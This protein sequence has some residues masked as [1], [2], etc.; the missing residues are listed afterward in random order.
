MMSLLVWNLYPS[1]K[2]M[3]MPEDCDLASMRLLTEYF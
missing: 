3:L 1:R 2:V